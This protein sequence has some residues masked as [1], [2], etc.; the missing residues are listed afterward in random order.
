MNTDLKELLGKKVRCGVT[1]IEGTCTGIAEY[2]NETASV[3]I[4]PR[5]GPTIVIP[6]KT[7]FWANAVT[8]EVI[9]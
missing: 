2:W 5:I 6:D 7:S 4:T 8:I 9:E 3:Q 1:G